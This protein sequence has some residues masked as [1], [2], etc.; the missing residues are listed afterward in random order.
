MRLPRRSRRTPRSKPWRSG[1]K[2]AL[3]AI[4]E[5][6]RNDIDAARG[7]GRDEAFIDRLALDEAR[8]KAM[9]KGLRDIASA[10]GSRRRG[11]GVVDAAERLADLARARAARRDRH[12]LRVEAERDGRRRRALPQVG[13]RGDLAERLRELP[14]LAR[15][16]QC[17]DRRPRRGRIAGGSDPARAD[18]AARGCRLHAR[19]SR[20]RYRRDRAARRQKPRRPRA[21]G[22]AG[23][24]VRASRR[25]LS[26]LCASAGRSRHGEDHRAQRQDA[27]DR[28]VRRG[29]DAAR[30]SRRGAD[31]SRAAGRCADRGGLRGEGRSRHAARRLHG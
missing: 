9:A 20:R 13:Q 24:G 26:R 28:R 3:R 22:G 8:V 27:A 16:L 29:G 4:L 11:D 18:G 31:P 10:A 21:G 30:R 25:H 19:R 15:D 23:A 1:S 14:H 2:R 5:A 7:K 17:A 6:N 12:H